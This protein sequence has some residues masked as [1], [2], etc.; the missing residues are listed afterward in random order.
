MA[1]IFDQDDLSNLDRLDRDAAKR[2]GAELRQELSAFLTPQQMSV[3]G[4]LV[5]L[6]TFIR[7]FFRSQAIVAEGRR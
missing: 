1:Q 6:D 2:V 4:G 3:L 7:G 5:G